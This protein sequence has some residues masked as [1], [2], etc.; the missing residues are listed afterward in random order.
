MNISPCFANLSKFGVIASVS[1]YDPNA[2]FKSSA[3]IN[4]TF[5]FLENL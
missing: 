5:S 2:Q 3:I 1:P 4:N